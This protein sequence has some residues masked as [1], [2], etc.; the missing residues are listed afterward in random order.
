MNEKLKD[1]TTATNLNVKVGDYVVVEFS[2]DDADIDVVTKVLPNGRFML[3]K[4]G[5]DYWRADGT[6]NTHALKGEKDYKVKKAF[7]NWDRTWCYS[8]LTAERLRD[9]AEMLEIR[10][11]SI[12]VET[13]RL[14]N[15]FLD[16][17][18]YKR[19]E[20]FNKD[21]EVNLI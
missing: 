20:Y 21:L 1:T 13:I 4:Y 5:D 7:G 6:K 15:K 14:L 16:F 19:K 8:E 12:D 17:M 10:D 11:D 9:V 3:K 2:K 18:G